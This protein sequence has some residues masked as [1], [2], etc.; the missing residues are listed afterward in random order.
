MD[1]VLV[2]Y[3]S[4]LRFGITDAVYEHVLESGSGFKND[5]IAPET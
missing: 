2:P 5:Y 4:F 1:C 3:R